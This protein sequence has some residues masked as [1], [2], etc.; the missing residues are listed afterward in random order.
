MSDQVY[1]A[2]NDRHRLR[3][4]ELRMPHVGA[5]Q[6]DVV[7]DDAIDPA[8]LVDGCSI[9]IGD[10]KARGTIV[11]AEPWQGTT[12]ARIVAGG[13]G[14]QKYVRGRYYSIASGVRRSTILADVAAEAGETMAPR[15]PDAV[16]SPWYVRQAAPASW[17]LQ[18][19]GLSW[20]VLDSGQTTYLPYPI[21][22]VGATFVS[23]GYD[24]H[25]GVVT[26]ATE[27]IERWRPNVTFSAPQ[28][29]REFRA[30]SIIH[31]MTA[32]TIRTE[33]WVR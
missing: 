25:R 19:L 20:R 28:L 21:G 32:G 24:A 6:A 5:W 7:T 15:L 26:V 13:G 12:R 16:L 31:R 17:T 23:M 11:R 10:F 1:A 29:P 2:L 22:P 4:L 9:S 33:V 3:Q 30:D 18:Q 14:W 8:L 27:A